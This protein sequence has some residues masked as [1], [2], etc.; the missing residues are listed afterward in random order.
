MGV[1]RDEVDCWG[2]GRSALMNI[3]SPP[4]S[5]AFLLPSCASV[6]LNPS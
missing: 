3:F 6:L 5:C 2:N 4:V 1:S